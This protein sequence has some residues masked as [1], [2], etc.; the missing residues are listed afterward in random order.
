MALMIDA[1]TLKS[2]LLSLEIAGD[3]G[4]DA[5]DAMMGMTTIYMIRP[6]SFL[7]WP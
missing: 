6:K 7:P 4:R 5:F 1:E 2:C 3:G